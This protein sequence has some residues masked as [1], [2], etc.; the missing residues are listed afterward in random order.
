M[1]RRPPARSDSATLEPR[2]FAPDST[3]RARSSRRTIGSILGRRASPSLPED[4]SPQLPTSGR[5][6]VGKDSESF[7]ASKIRPRGVRRRNPSNPSGPCTLTLRR[8]MPHN[9][10]PISGEPR[11]KRL[12][13]GKRSSPDDASR[14]PAEGRFG[15]RLRDGLGQRLVRLHW[16]VM[17]RVGHELPGVV[18][19]LEG[20]DS[21][22]EFLIV[23]LGR[24]S[25]AL[26]FGESVGGQASILG[27]SKVAPELP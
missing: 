12:T 3:E 4:R 2:R 5:S 18:W 8:S 1:R 17:R 25:T 16:F 13:I 11:Y 14:P 21:R 24:R 10:S 26:E 7:V 9:G 23:I 22:F 19:I 27:A 6:G 20:G 15:R